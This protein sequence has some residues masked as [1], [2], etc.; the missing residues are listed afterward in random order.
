MKQEKFKEVTNFNGATAVYYKNFFLGQYNEVI[1]PE[2]EQ[3]SGNKNSI[4]CA[5][6]SIQ[7]MRTKTKNK[8]NTRIGIVGNQMYLSIKAE[9]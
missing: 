9:K 3:F 4:F 6:I 2:F 5:N 8:L 7:Y 1:S